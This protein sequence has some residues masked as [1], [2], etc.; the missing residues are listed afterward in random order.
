MGSYI[1]TPAAMIDDKWSVYME[2]ER[3]SRGWRTLL[4]EFTV[5]QMREQTEKKE[6]RGAWMRGERRG[7]SVNREPDLSSE[8]RWL[9][10][11]AERKWRRTSGKKYKI[12]INCP[13]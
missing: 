6:H 13:F 7:G 2:G 1:W 12:F 5:Q 4:P 9:R 8:A 3:E 11:A 10:H